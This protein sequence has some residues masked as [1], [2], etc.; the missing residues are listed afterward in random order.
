MKYK[1]L[2]WMLYSKGMLHHIYN[3]K[4]DNQAMEKHI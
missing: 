3:T 2:R 1:Y 4:L